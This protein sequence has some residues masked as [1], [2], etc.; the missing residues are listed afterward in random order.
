MQTPTDDTLVNAARRGD[1]GAFSS[2]VTRHKRRVFGLAARFAKDPDELEDICQE[3]FIKAYENLGKFRGDA[4]FEHWLIRIATHACHDVLRKRRRESGNASYDTL[5]HGV[6]DLAAEAR[7]TAHE[8]RT[9]LKWALSSLTPDEQMA[10]ILL[11]LEEYSVKEVAELT[12]WSESNVKVRGHR[13]RQA[14]KRI[15]EENNAR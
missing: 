3:V 4:P 9:L 2:L 12:G 8:A 5:V 11:E 1:E 6:A 13:A 14:L 15:L 7:H 10:I